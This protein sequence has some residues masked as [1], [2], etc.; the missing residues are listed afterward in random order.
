MC[1]QKKTFW[2]VRAGNQIG[3]QFFFP[4]LKKIERKKNSAHGGVLDVIYLDKKHG[5]E[6]AS[7]RQ[8]GRKISRI[9]TKL[10]SIEFF[11]TSPRVLRNDWN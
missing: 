8:F 3:S 2:V 6:L 1:P 10:L 11:V 7:V 9:H 4:S 5:F